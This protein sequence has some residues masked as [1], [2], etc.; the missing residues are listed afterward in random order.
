[1]M[2][3]MP[4]LGKI[5]FDFCFSTLIYKCMIVSLYINV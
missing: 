5:K 3:E 2:L 1:M 4:S